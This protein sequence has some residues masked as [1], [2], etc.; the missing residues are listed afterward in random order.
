M[1]CLGKYNGTT[2]AHIA[3]TRHDGIDYLRGSNGGYNGDIIPAFE[4]G[5]ALLEKFNFTFDVQ[6]APVQLLAASK[7]CTRHPS[8][9]VVID[10]LGKPR[11]LLGAD[12]D[13]NNKKVND[14]ELNVWR[15]G[16]K[17]MA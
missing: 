16:M 9:K 13:I 17:A 8:I 5:F 14:A 1:D 12:T 15:K 3:T 7:L 6:C 10:H 2:A 4:N 11:M